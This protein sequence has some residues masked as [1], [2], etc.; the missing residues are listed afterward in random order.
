M[1]CLITAIFTYHATLPQAFRLRNIFPAEREHMRIEDA[2]LSP[3]A[4]FTRLE[5]Q[6]ATNNPVKT[7]TWDG[8]DYIEHLPE[9]IDALTNLTSITIQNQN[10]RLLPASI[11]S[12]PHLESLVI[13]NTPITRLPET[14]GNL[15]SLKRLLI[16]GTKIKN[17]PMAIGN[18]TNLTELNLSYNDIDRMP[19]TLV[20]LPNLKM[21]DLSGNH[22][23]HIPKNL[24]PNWRFVFFAGNRISRA[25]LS[26][27]DYDKP[28]LGVHY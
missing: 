20:D 5:E 8:R 9:N 6:N 26:K 4:A 14:I 13:I 18:L 19:D 11:G 21:L 17:V 15:T 27:F 2:T 28:G 10:L 3:E 23:T 25:E 24:P 22:L 7:L 1:L 16:I 12:L